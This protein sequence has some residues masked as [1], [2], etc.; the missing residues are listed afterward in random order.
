M[1]GHASTV[2]HAGNYIIT[3]TLRIEQPAATLFLCDHRWVAGIIRG[4]ANSPTPSTIV[5]PDSTPGRGC[6]ETR[7]CWRL[8]SLCN[9][10]V[11]ANA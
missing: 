9:A 10:L 7:L 8:L 3:D 1:L 5:V 2:L 4:N 11:V 6:S